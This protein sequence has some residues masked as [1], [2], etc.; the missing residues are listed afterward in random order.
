[1]RDV[2][3]KAAKPKPDYALAA[4]EKMEAKGDDSWMP[5]H[6]RPRRVSTA[7]KAYFDGLRPRALAEIRR[8]AVAGAD[9]V[10]AALLTAQIFQVL[11]GLCAIL[12]HNYSPWVGFK[13]GKGVATSGPGTMP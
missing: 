6:P 3:A 4:I 10:H 5:S 13:G 9:P 8:A 1:M 11:T 12:G 2:P 7:L